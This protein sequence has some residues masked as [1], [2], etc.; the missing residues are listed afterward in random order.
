MLKPLIQV[1]RYFGI[2]FFVFGGFVLLKLSKIEFNAL[3][4]MLETSNSPQLKIVA[5]FAVI[6]LG[7]LLLL[8]GLVSFFFFDKK[9][10]SEVNLF[11]FA[12]FFICFVL[13][14]M[15]A[16]F[17]INKKIKPIN[18]PSFYANGFCSNDF[19]KLELIQKDLSAINHGNHHPIL[20][21]VSNKNKQTE[22]KL[23]PKILFYGD[24]FMEGVISSHLSISSFVQKL[25]PAYQTLNFGV[26]GY[27]VDQ[28]W[29]NF[30]ESIKK[31]P[32]ATVV[33]SLLTEDLDRSILQLRGSP[34]PFYKK[35]EKGEWGLQGV[36]LN[37]DIQRWIN[38]NPIQIKSYSYALIKTG[39]NLVLNLFDGSNSDCLKD[40]KKDVNQF[41]F[42]QLI[43]TAKENNHPLLIL[44]FVT[45]R[46]FFKRDPW[47]H[48]FVTSYFEEKNIPVVDTLRVIKEDM[49]KTN[50]SLNEYF[51]P[52]DGHPNALGNQVIAK[53][54]FKTLKEKKTLEKLALSSG[55]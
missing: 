41:I 25:V 9:N 55:K 33:F 35:N 21:W 5:I 15:T 20:G 28:I 29:L 39:L 8:W 14:E 30:R 11:L 26:G 45:Q 49:K 48:K 10:I 50:R 36:P 38:D 24:S 23:R 54:I 1:N 42:D 13:F 22:K 16:R 37:R 47:R 51:I 53:A 46:T 19:W 6:L 2:L 43:V 32:K 40:E 52:N 27:G 31:F 12:S 4:V 17:A 34:K 3:S 44:L 18:N 7:I